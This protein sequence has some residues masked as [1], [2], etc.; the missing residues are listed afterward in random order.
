[1][2]KL[3]LSRNFLAAIVVAAAGAWAQDIITM[4]DGSEIQAVV[5]DVGVDAIKYKKYNYQDGPFF[6]VGIS[7]V[8]SIKYRNGEKDVFEAKENPPAYTPPQPLYFPVYVPQYMPNAPDISHRPAKNYVRGD[9]SGRMF[10]FSVRSENLFGSMMNTGGLF[11][12]G[13]IGANG[14]YFSGEVG[15][16]VFYFGGGFN[17]GGCINKDGTIKNVLGI[18]AGNWWTEGLG[19]TSYSGY[20]DNWVMDY[21]YYNDD[22]NGF[23]FGGP[24]WKIMFGS[25]GNFDITNKWLF[26]VRRVEDREFYNWGLDNYYKT[27]NFTYSLSLGWTLTKRR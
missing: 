24:F 22:G 5:V 2:K 23:N 19:G 18:T 7:K 25:K 11:E 15:G 13:V 17:F 4:R 21:Y 26:G 27:F 9:E 16:G 20:S 8:F 6:V 3:D 1:M 10:V 14:F 12:C